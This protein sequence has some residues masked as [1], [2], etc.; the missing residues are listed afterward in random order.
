MRFIL[1]KLPS[2]PRPLLSSPSLGQTLGIANSVGFE[3]AGEAKVVSEDH[4]SGVADG[5]GRWIVWHTPSEPYG[6]L[7]CA[8]DE[9]APGSQ[10][11]P[12]YS[13]TLSSHEL[14][15]CYTFSE[16]FWQFPW[17][18]SLNIQSSL[19]R[20]ELR[21]DHVLGIWCQAN[22][23]ICPLE[24]AEYL[25]LHIRWWH[26][27]PLKIPIWRIVIIENKIWSTLWDMMYKGLR[28]QWCRIMAD[29]AQ[30]ITHTMPGTDVKFN[31]RL[32]CLSWS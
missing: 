19:A 1:P 26:K 20:R 8:S 2:G 12:E 7:P 9:W 30:T 11:H 23:L 27:C 29:C 21:I 24:P 17:T 28:S 16:R 3:G 15:G 4:V 18:I 31:P 6:G 14:G 22:N 32:C 25:I 13:S 5:A 10:Y